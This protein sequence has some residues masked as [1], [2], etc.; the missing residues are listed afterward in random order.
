MMSGKLEDIMLFEVKDFFGTDLNKINQNAQYKSLF[1]KYYKVDT[2]TNKELAYSLAQFIRTLVSGTTK[3]DLTLKGQASF[4]A[5]EYRGYTIFF[6]EK[7]D[8]FHCHVN[9]TTTDNQFHNTGLDSIYA[10]EADKGYYNTT[11]K[12]ADLGKFLTP[13]LRNVALRDHFMHD[14]RFTSLSDVIDFYDHGM[15]KVSNLDPIMALPAKATG[16]HLTTTEKN[17]LI[18]FLKTFTDSTFITNTK[19]S[20]P[21]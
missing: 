6:T 13:T 11:G 4:T 5:D 8:C 1:K 16:L 14:G 7:G 21:F 19:F 17:Q 20:S 2:I 18:A 15:H 9:P 10:K 3:Y 12:T